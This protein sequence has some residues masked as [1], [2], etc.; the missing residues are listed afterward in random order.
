[1]MKVK[2]TAACAASVAEIEPEKKKKVTCDM[3][4]I[5]E[6]KFTVGVG[7]GQPRAQKKVVSA[8]DSNSSCVP[9]RARAISLDAAC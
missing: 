1:M 3:N 5:A 7:R 9:L 4:V 2:K 8:T 6:S